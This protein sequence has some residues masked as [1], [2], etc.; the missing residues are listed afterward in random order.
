MHALPKA[1]AQ[2]RMVMTQVESA[3][4]R[5][6]AQVFSRP[7]RRSDPHLQRG[8][9]YR[10]D[11]RC[12]EARFPE[13]VVL[14]SGS[15]DGT[16]DIVAAIRQCTARSFV[17]STAHAVQWNYGLTSCGL[18]R[19][20]V[21][22]LDADYVVSPGLVDEIAA[23][24]PGHDVS[25]YRI[26]FRYC[27]NG[28]PLSG[29]LYPPQVALYRA[30]PSHVRADRAYPARRR[31]WPRSRSLRGRDRSRRSASRCRAGSPPSRRYAK[32][33]AALPPDARRIATICAG[34]SG[35][36]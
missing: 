31:R 33:E 16:L 30:R 20:W 21:L 36:A 22:A 4:Q 18:A 27:I 7:H 13:V 32:L 9:Q 14:D 12:L 19:P 23:L 1:P 3:R 26:A 8:S 5:R 10:P 6:R 29:S 25:G 11:A 35:F 2:R 28:Q 17:P 34:R 15:T 24:R